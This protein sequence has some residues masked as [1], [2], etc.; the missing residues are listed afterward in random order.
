MSILLKLLTV[1]FILAVI[2]LAGFTAYYFFVFQPQ[3]MAFITAKGEEQKACVA[4]KENRY[5][6]F[7]DRECRGLGYREKCRLPAE[8]LQRLDKT[9]SDDKNACSVNYTEAL[10]T[11]NYVFPWDKP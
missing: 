1:L 8:I 10:K 6:E 9:M 3:K 7:W 4:D 5:N 11:V 2:T